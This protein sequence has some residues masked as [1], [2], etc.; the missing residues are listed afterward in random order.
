MML[1]ACS[2]GPVRTYHAGKNFSEFPGDRRGASENASARASRLRAVFVVDI[3]EKV[4][5]IPSKD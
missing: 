1:G 3:D 4:L 2:R 5:T